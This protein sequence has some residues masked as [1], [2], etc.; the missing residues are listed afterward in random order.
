MKDGKTKFKRRLERTDNA[1]Y[2]E[3]TEMINRGSMRTVAYNH[4]AK[5]YKKSGVSGV[6]LAIQRE[7]KRREQQE[8]EREV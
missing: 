3:F 1:I 8:L 5:K 2:A 4:L 6:I 7:T